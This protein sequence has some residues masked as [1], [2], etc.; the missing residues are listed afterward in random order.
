M[1]DL[2]DIHTHSISSG[3]A[4]STL[5]ENIQAAMEKGLKYYGL[6]DHAP[7]MPGA[8][9]GIHFGNMRVI[10]KELNGL[11]ILT[12][13]EL[14]IMDPKGTVDLKEHTIANLDYAI[15]SLHIPCF[16]PTTKEDHTQAY[17]EVLKN[18]YLKVLGHPDDGRFPFDVEAVIKQAKQY[19]VAIEINNSSLKPD[20]FR[21]NAKE[22]LREVL[23]YCTLY[24]VPVIMSSDAH[25][26][27][28]IGNH[29]YAE[30]FLQEQNF[31]PEL[32]INYHEHLI[33]EYILDPKRV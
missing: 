2:I 16:T 8:S 10:P 22:T 12:G 4:Y 6:S 21:V 29:Q 18:P 15:A 20:A 23:H 11:T 31:D 33:K 13:V 7:E 19:H 28:D 5:Q 9:H 27:Y 24:Q 17:L 25:I 32:I 1:K 14:N 26:S 30:Q 3:H